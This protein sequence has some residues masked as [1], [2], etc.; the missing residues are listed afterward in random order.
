MGNTKRYSGL[1]ICPLLA[2]LLS[3]CPGTDPLGSSGSET[4][5]PPTPIDGTWDLLIAEESTPWGCPVILGLEVIDFVPF[6][7]ASIAST[8]Q[9]EGGSRDENTV[10]LR[11][12][13]Q[14]DCEECG[15]WTNVFKGDVAEDGMAI[16]G[17][18]WTTHNAESPMIVQSATMIKR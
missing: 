15:I 16:D 6:C 5:P 4:E 17:T 12:R 1:A 11:W 2:T 10:T 18:L 14:L 8:S 7:D 3:G 13:H 9:D